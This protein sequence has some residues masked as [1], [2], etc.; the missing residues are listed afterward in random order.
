MNE[1]VAIQINNEDYVM[2]LDIKAL[3]YFTPLYQAETGNK[4]A[5]FIDAYIAMQQSQ[6]MTAIAC[7]LAGVVR[8][9][10]KAK[11]VGLDFIDSISAN[12]IMYL[13]SKL[14]E[15]VSSSMP[16]GEENTEGK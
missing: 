16:K 6:D 13:I 5:T 14:G 12:E 8:K 11:P 2:C 15:C 10:Q 4:K 7:L 9:H 3:R 1:A